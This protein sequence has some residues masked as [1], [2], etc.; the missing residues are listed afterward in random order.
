MGATSKAIGLGERCYGKLVD[1]NVSWR[2][3]TPLTDLIAGVR[4]RLPRP[5]LPT[6]NGVET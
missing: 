3:D 5:V 6:A 1:K 2:Q 4:A